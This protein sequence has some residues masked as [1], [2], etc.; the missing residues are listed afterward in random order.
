MMTTTNTPHQASKEN[1]AVPVSVPVDQELM[2]LSLDTEIKPSAPK[3]A[4]GQGGGPAG[5]AGPPKA[6][7]SNAAP[8][9][10][11]TPAQ[12]EAVRQK[13]LLALKQQQAAQAKAAALK[14]HPL[15]PSAAVTTASATAGQ[16]VA[17]LKKFEGQ[18][19]GINYDN[20]AEIREAELVHVNDEYF[21][22]YAKD[23]KLRFN[24]P[25]RTLLSV[26]EGE[27]GVEA[28]V[29]G[30][31]VKMKAVLKVYPLLLF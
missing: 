21:S 10:A 26:V 23:R 5:P 28:V 4:S 19:V 17:L 29:S 2:E 16:T 8:A 12:V 20:S 24:F 3:T 9:G 22:V 27:D 15:P 6:A 30:A 7:A 18:S 14:A 1:A 11:L 25:L 31:N 13:K